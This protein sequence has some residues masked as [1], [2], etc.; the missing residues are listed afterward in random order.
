MFEGPPRKRPLLIGISGGS[1]SGKTSLARFLKEGLGDKAVI[2][3]Q[4]WYYEDNGGLTP[5]QSKELNFDHPSAIESSLFRKQLDVLMRGR[6]IEAP[7]YDYASHTRARETRTVASAPVVIVDGLFVLCDKRLLRRLDLSVYVEVP[8]DER[9]LRR[10]RRDVEERRVDLEET[11]RLYERFVRPMH[12]KH[13]QP[14]SRNATWRWH[15]LED[16]RFRHELLR[17]IKHRLRQLSL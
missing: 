13:I 9:L 2:V 14:A 1:A 8:D 6:P 5:E 16:R 17:D 10:V 4:D 3:C 11:L 15:Q 12:K 7:L